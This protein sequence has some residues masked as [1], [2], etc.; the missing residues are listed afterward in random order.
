MKKFLSEFKK[1]ALRGNV[2]D[3]AVGVIIGG[4][5]QAIVSSLVGD[6]ISPLLG[7]IAKEDFSGWVWT[8]GGVEVK[9]G[10]FLT[11]VI[12]FLLMALVIFLLLRGLNKLLSIGKK[13]EAPKAPTTK[14]CPFCKSE[15]AL[16]ATRCP[17]CTSVLEEAAEEK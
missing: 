11:A 15:I 8:V 7:L 12:N 10:S 2:I 5:F 17:H 13:P 3:L 16:D 6:V 14:I 9:Y 4:A 1:F